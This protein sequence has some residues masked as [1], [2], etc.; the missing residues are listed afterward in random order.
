MIIDIFQR[1]LA[2]L[3][4]VDRA[5]V[6][7]VGLL[8]GAFVQYWRERI[9]FKI[10]AFERFRR[11][12]SE[13]PDFVA[14]KR[15]IQDWAN[16]HEYEGYIE[17]AAITYHELQAYLDLMEQIAIYQKWGLVHFR[18]LDEILGDDLMD[19]Y[20]YCADHHIL[21]AYESM[22]PSADYYG[23]F[24]RLAQ[25]LERCEKR[26]QRMYSLLTRPWR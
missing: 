4:Q 3:A 10:E 9:W 2:P 16:H 5:L 7:V 13:K 19:C 14:I 24:A 25:K 8:A 11:E 12:L 18:L 15:K 26:R 20:D 22:D 1:I 21:E 23:Y 6:F 17:G